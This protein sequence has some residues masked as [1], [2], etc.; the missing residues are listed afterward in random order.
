MLTVHEKSLYS[1][2]VQRYN[3][4]CQ[5][6]RL[7]LGKSL[8]EIV[9][10]HRNLDVRVQGLIDS[11]EGDSPQVQSLKRKKLKLKDMITAVQNRRKLF[12]PA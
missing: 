3:G 4:R 7:I 5:M 11:G 1:V 10:E 9:A 2:P 8:E 6:W 12:L